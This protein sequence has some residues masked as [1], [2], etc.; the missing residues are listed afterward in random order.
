MILGWM[1]KRSAAAAAG[2]KAAVRAAP[3][4][5]SLAAHL[6]VAAI[7]SLT[8][9]AIIRSAS[10]G[11]TI[12]PDAHLSDT[13]GGKR[14][15]SSADD[16]PETSIGQAVTA[17]SAM[18]VTA[19]EAPT[20]ILGLGA[21]AGGNSGDNAEGMQLI[22]L[23][24]GAPSALMGL[25]PPAPMTA[26]A[27]A[28]KFFGTGGNAH[29]VVYLVDW[30]GSMFAEGRYET[31]QLELLRSLGDLQDSQ[32]FAILFFTQGAPQEV[33]PGQLVAAGDEQRAAAGRYMRDK[34]GP[35]GSAA[36]GP[37][38]GTDPIPALRRAFE[39]LHQPTNSKPGKLI[40]LLTDG[41]F[42]DNK[43]V[44]AELARLNRGREVHIN[45]ILYATSLELSSGSTVQDMMKAIATAHGGTYK[46]VKVDE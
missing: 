45:T 18:Q 40:Y 14:L 34:I 7:L 12:I 32:D 20:G 41:D 35:P 13:P 23:G 39:V 4:A 6:V 38:M 16:P 9:L 27:P 30:S 8:G 5:V 10:E 22:G 3:W 26:V 37:M 2:G 31:V 21:A 1:R 28:T 15:S 33:P 17:R 42:A 46:W 44:L 43:A 24:G 11:Q 29:H 25:A 36:A 19:V